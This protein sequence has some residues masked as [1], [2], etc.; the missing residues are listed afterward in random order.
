MA[1]GSQFSIDVVAALNTDNVPKQLD[2]LN[3]RLTKTTSNMVKIPVGIDEN[4]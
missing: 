1:N 3:A 2:E 4:G